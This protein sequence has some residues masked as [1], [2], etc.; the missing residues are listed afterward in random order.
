MPKEEG[1]EQGL[2][3]L[4]EGYLYIPNRTHSLQNEIFETRLLGQKA[5]CMTGQE[6]AELF[7][8]N[9]KFIRSGVS[10]KRVQKTL[11]GEGGVQS[12]DGEEHRHRKAMFMD[13]MGSQALIKMQQI[14]EE[15]W[16]DALDRW[17]G[18]ASIKL[19]EEAQ[20]LLMRAVCRWAGVP[21]EENKVK[22]RTQ[23]MVDLFETPMT[24]GL[25]HHA[26]RQARRI[27][28][29]W[30]AD[31][32]E[33]VR[34][35]KLQAQKD[36]VL[37]QFSTHKDLEGELLDKYTAAVE[38][39]NILRPTVAVSVYITFLG[40]SLYHHPA[41]KKKLAAQDDTSLSNF[42]EEVRRYYPFFPF[43]AAQV[44]KDFTWKG[45]KFEKGTMT[46]LDFYGTN[47][48]PK[49][50]EQPGLFQPDRFFE[51]TENPFDLIPQ[52]GG[53]YYTNHRCAG[54]W[55]TQDIMKISL[56]YLANKITYDV[57]SQDLTFSLT[58]APTTPKSGFIIE[59]IIRK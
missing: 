54:E 15:E 37:F 56:N 19:Y 21:L 26:G 3:I 6:A 32:V 50:W 57:P 39:L 51:R 11:V 48:N 38:I 10:P 22:R 7:Y 46:L 13:Q 4:R 43:N 1:M 40:L 29:K 35:G 42:V 52:G 5:Y 33:A 8:D 18:K 34:E 27:S 14:I 12:L 55:L 9:D 16:E 36:T 44:K 24:F 53:D 28:E 47:H 31:K 49:L 17:M 45:Y 59:N 20:E 41:E 23:H 2:S 25:K 58:H 30:I